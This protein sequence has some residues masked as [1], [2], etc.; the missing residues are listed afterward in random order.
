MAGRVPQTETA[1]DFRAWTLVPVGH[2]RTTAVPTRAGRAMNY[3]ISVQGSRQATGR[4]LRPRQLVEQAL[5]LSLRCERDLNAA[6]TA[7]PHDPDSCAEGSPEAVLC[8][9]VVDILHPGR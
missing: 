4:R 8:R 3:N 2:E 1:R 6:L 5:Q 7:L 9:P